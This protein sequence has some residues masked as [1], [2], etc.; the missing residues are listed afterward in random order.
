[1]GA[2]PVSALLQVQGL[3]VDYRTAA[4]PL[5]ALDGVDLAVDPGEVVAVVGESGSGKSTL[6]HAVVGLLPANGR[7]TAG[8]VVLAGEDV[9]GLPEKAMRRVRGRRVGLVPQDPTVSLNPVQRV[10]E[11]VAEVLRVH[12]LAD[13]RAA[14]LRAVDL[15]ERAGLPEPA[16]RA[17]QHPH[18]LSGGMRQRVLI[19]IAIAA[20]PALIIAD[21]PTSAL[22]ATVQRRILDH[23][24][25]L[26]RG[27]GT[28]MLLVTH[29]LG[30]AADRADRLVVM[31]GGR[32]VETGRTADVLDAPR[33]TYTR[34]LV[35]AAPPGSRNSLTR[36]RTSTSG[37][38]WRTG[39][40]PCSPRTT[41]RR[42]GAARTRVRV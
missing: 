4:G 29:D 5:P 7:V 39:S 17:R 31:S 38:A 22:D 32:V 19:A 34:T 36:S 15:L 16:V 35:R 8:R 1:V 24:E 18:E 40:G 3:R 26:I 9:T 33:E 42:P 14:R 12:G 21:E 27:S 6:A 37:R 25:G 28:G 10:G 23:L 11:Q 30:V 2:V 20:D 41:G 13:R